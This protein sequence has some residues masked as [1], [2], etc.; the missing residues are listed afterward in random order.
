MYIGSN[1]QRWGQVRRLLEQLGGAG[2]EVGPACLTGWDWGARPEW[3]VKTGILGID[4]DAD[5]LAS[6]GVEIRNGIRF[7]EVVR[8]L[9]K[10]RFAPIIHR[11]LFR[12]LGIVTNRTFE[13]FYADTL[14]MLLLPQDFVSAVYGPAALALV[15]GD[16][17]AAFMADALEHPEPYW[18]A[19]LETRASLAR[20][21][22]YA[23][24]FKE[25]E[26]AV[27]HKAMAGA[28]R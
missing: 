9:G 12:Q 27:G 11:P 2:A 1:W 14:P 6:L 17:V 8:L 19:V 28:V 16:D 26:A 24:R 18:E 21:H 5:F 20:N 23:Q 22:S 10:A 13:T 3:A 4:T 7:D 25:L 15:P